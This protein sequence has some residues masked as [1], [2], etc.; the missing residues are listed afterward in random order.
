MTKK[1]KKSELNRYSRSYGMWILFANLQSWWI[2]YEIEDYT[3][4]VAMTI[5]CFLALCGIVIDM[6]D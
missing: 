1:K 5:I 4:S 2:G 3:Y 6:R